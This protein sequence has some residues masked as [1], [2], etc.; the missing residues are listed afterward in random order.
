MV[1][2]KDGSW[3]PCGDYRHLSLVTTPDKYH[4]PNMQDLSN[5]LHGCNLLSK[6]FKQAKWCYNRRFWFVCGCNRNLVI[7]F[8]KI[9]FW[10]NIAT[11]QTI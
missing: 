8:D 9:N 1:P 7:T 4:L 2:Q 6:I 11:M 10:I 5:G 3:R